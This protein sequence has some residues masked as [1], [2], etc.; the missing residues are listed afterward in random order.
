[1]AG[2]LD[3][4]VAIVTGGGS[5][6]GRAAAL[7]FASEGAKLVVA[8]VPEAASMAVAAEIGAAGGAAVGIKADV[9]NPAEVEAMVQAALTQ[10]GGLDVIFNNAGTTHD[11]L[12][13]DT[14][15]EIW[16]A[17]V[18]PT[19]KGVFLGCS[20][21]IR[22]MKRQGRGGSIVNSA[23][24]A[25][26]VGFTRRSAYCAA[27]GGVIALTRALAV[28]CAGAGIR[29][30]CI[31]PGATDTAMVRDLYQLQADP[32]AAQRAHAARQPFGRLSTAE[33]IARS[34]LFLA[35]DDAATMTGTCLV[36]DSGYVAG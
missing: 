30:N 8:G 12:A 18:D 4:K 17:V 15:P 29:V 33:E 9:T 22:A 10:F 36:V 11:T 25:G 3:G 16:D 19:L 14:T 23:S 24:T 32:A 1:M 20:H 21:A 34:V 5:G 13:E 28:E 2:K 31:A 26:L 7:L 35:S 27:K 6:I